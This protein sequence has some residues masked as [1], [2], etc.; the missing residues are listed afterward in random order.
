MMQPPSSIPNFS[1][2]P[3]GFSPFSSSS[4]GGPSAGGGPRMSEANQ[5]LWVETKTGDG[6]VL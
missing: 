2:P 5:E 6:K 3:P 1:L 4:D